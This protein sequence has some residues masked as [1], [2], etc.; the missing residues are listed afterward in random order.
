MVAGEH[1]IVSYHNLSSADT[2]CN[3]AKLLKEQG[4]QSI[5][6]CISH[7]TLSKDTARMIEQSDLDKVYITD[8]TSNPEH[9]STENSK[10]TVLPFFPQLLGN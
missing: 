4:A 1:C 6:A 9:I 8:S 10:I 5:T 3:N 2:L 7:I